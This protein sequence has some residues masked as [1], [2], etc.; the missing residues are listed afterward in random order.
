[1][2][3]ATAGHIDH[4]KTRL[5]GA[6][7][8]VDTDR[9]P[10]EKARGISIDL[11]FAYWP[12]PS[13]A[14]IGFV[15]VPGHERFVRNMLAGVCG[16]DFAML[17]VAADDGVMPQ[18]VEHLQILDLLGIRRGLAA[19]TKV[20]R[21][22][23]PR[24]A[25][26]RREIEDLLA[27]TALQGI[28]I[29]EVS[30][31][32]GEGI[33]EVKAALAAAAQS[34]QSRLRTGQHFRFA[35]DRAFSIGGSGTVVTGTVFSGEVDVGA[36]LVVSPRGV[37]VRIRGMRVHASEVQHVQA[38][39]RCALNLSGMAVDAIARGDWVVSE[40]IH[41]PTQRVDADFVLLQGASVALKPSTR[42]HLHLGATDVLARMMPIEAKAIAPGTHTAVELVLENPVG[43]LHGD[44]FVVR[45]SAAHRT[46]GGG[47]V[48][49][50][51]AGASRRRREA[52][53]SRLAALAT[54]S[55]QQAL[56]AL[57]QRP[58]VVD[59]DQF[60]TMFNLV[61]EAASALYTA[62]GIA[63]IGEHRIG[64]P[65][66]RRE[67]WSRALLTRLADYHA[68]NPSAAGMQVKAL[69]DAIAPALSLRDF[70]SFVEQIAG[71]GRFVVK[72]GIVRLAEHDAAANPA[73]RALWE[74]VHPAMLAAGNQPSRPSEIATEV[75]LDE[76]AVR[77]MLYRKR[78]AGAVYRVGQDRFCLR[79]TLARLAAIATST[80]RSSGNASFTAAEYR[81]ATGLGRTLAIEILE[82]LDALGVTLRVGDARRINRDYVPL[83][84]DAA[85]VTKPVVAAPTKPEAAGG[86]GGI[87][88]SGRHASN[89]K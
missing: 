49:D 33:A 9:L 11:G 36:R 13:G 37:A 75:R 32:T 76:R 78:A 85:P 84:G 46:L 88:I 45:D 14:L 35:V 53:A 42:V 43:A 40:A 62:A 6:I 29:V 67:E 8:G 71:G 28:D 47:T 80:A 2:I 12:S 56:Q 4:G 25:E 7:T 44:R 39:Q 77:D 74:R 34:S 61:P 27:G 38:G 64:I 72:G 26:V 63:R 52:R 68:K 65:S 87:H 70:Q 22:D 89:R 18:T 69:R 16:I 58:E 79:E 1:M 81:D 3:V 21:V 30:A 48:L 41:R 57:L 59:L 10:E 50:P 51:F 66:V 86:R 55:P 82:A 19:M 54:D 73:D 31:V 17:I 24:R 15:D 23:V 5:V 83:L 60:E 20:D